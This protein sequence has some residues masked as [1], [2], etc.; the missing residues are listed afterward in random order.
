MAIVITTQPQSQALDI[1][2][3]LTL[4]YEATGGNPVVEGCPL[5]ESF[6]NENFDNVQDA[7]IYTTQYLLVDLTKLTMTFQ[8]SGNNEDTMCG[9]RMKSYTNSFSDVFKIHFENFGGYY[10]FQPKLYIGGN[11]V[12]EFERRSYTWPRSDWLT[13]YYG[14]TFKFTDIQEATG[15]SIDIDYIITILL[16]EEEVETFS[17]SFQIDLAFYEKFFTKSYT[18][19]AGISHN[20][21]QGFG[22]SEACQ[23]QTITYITQWK[24]DTI[25]IN[26]ANSNPLVI[27]NIQESDFASYTVEVSDGVLSTLSDEA[28]ISKAIAPVPVVGIPGAIT[29]IVEFP[30]GEHDLFGATSAIVHGNSGGA[31]IHAISVAP[32]PTD[33]Y[34]LDWGGGY[35]NPL[36]SFF[37]LFI[38]RFLTRVDTIDQLLLN[39][40]ASVV[41]GD[42]V[43][44]RTP[45]FPWQYHELLRKIEYLYGFSTNVPDPNFP[46]NDRIGGVHYPVRLKVPNLPIALSNPMNGI[47]VT[48][49]F[50]VTLINGDGFFDFQNAKDIMNSPVVLKKSSTVP[51]TIDTFNKIRQGDVENATLSEITYTI[52]GSDLLRSLEQPATRT[53]EEA[54][55]TGGGDNMPV[56]YGTIRKAALIQSGVGEFIACDPDY[57]T[58]VT[59][60]YDGDGASIPFTLR[61]S[62]KIV[63][64]ESAETVDFKGKQNNSIG[65]I[66]INELNLKSNIIYDDFFWNIPESENYRNNSYLVDFLFNDGSVK[67]LVSQILKNDM[68]FLIQQNNGKL[69]IRKWG[70][71]YTKHTY[72][73]WLI[74]G[75]P[76]RKLSDYKFYS[77]SVIMKYFI[78][79]GEQQISYLNDSVE[80]ETISQWKK[81]TR[82]THKTAHSSEGSV[83]EL[84]NE[85]LARFAN[86]PELWNVPTGAD[87]AAVELLDSLELEIVIGDLPKRR[88]MS[89]VIDWKIVGIN[90]GQ[91]VLQL[92]E[93]TTVVKV[94]EDFPLSHPSS[95]EGDGYLAQPPNEDDGGLM[96]Q[97]IVG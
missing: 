68:A 12:H 19:Q 47:F 15:T 51:A 95:E 79:E 34:W 97:K 26:D 60:V 36:D 59:T 16:N 80:A 45:F 21:F 14:A 67:S 27:P 71:T 49:S 70:E 65:S 76:I 94:V 32:Y 37:V 43:Y 44:F 48:P 77:S 50:S 58:E 20:Y 8:G 6:V 13:E 31:I 9:V 75:R 85:F 53:L 11:L 42:I 61:E 55:F 88:I 91:D 54:G 69:T 92:E 38:E 64:D 23:G 86:R 46:S 57:L 22:F 17:G 56:A 33:S 78:S 4:S 24:K 62:G 89:K 35:D 66:I 41:V 30:K 1:G 5:G 87:T 52:I 83:W 84:S 7:Y 73:A 10:D 93:D 3:E 74:T 39:E 28:I 81:K 72:K 40:Y 63:C 96:S 2:D 82:L 90:P 25:D 18:S 29:F